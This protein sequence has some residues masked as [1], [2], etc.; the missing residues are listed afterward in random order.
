MHR[1][2]AA[3][4]A[5]YLRECGDAYILIHRAPDGDCIGA[6]YS[7]QAVLRQIGKKARVLCADP[8]PQRFSF[9]LPEEPEEEF[10]PD[11][12]LSVD[13]AD[14][15]LFGELTETYQGRID[16]CIDH[17]ISNQLYAE[18]VLLE[19][20]AAATCE[21][22]YQV[23]W[24]MGITFT[25]QITKCLYTGMATDTGCFRFANTTP[26]THSYTAELMRQ[27]PDIRYDLI[28]RAMFTVKTRQQIQ[29][30]ITML[31]NIEY[32]LDGKCVMLWATHDICSDAGVNIEDMEGLTSLSLQPE[33]VEVGITVRE[34]KP[35]EFKISMRSARDI[36]VS[37]LC[38][39]LG[40]GGHIRAAGCTIKGTVAEV[41][42]KLL[43]IV[44]GVLS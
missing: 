1:I 9:L 8:I 42:E 12:I 7:L 17:H 44:S 38:A 18:R 20:C 10:T 15:L 32:Y 23:Y 16:L 40:G 27:F 14:E 6:G 34:R 3:E 21:V 37:A 41:R 31:R 19:E 13:V 4:A 36:N 30:E 29:A 24:E 33:G 2:T 26:E 22:L 39:K 25:E 43:A 28:N 11:C 5:A 35:G